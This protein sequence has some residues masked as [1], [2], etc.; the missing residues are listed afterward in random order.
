MLLLN[1]PLITHTHLI[2]C[3]RRLQVGWNQ[4]GGRN[5]S[6]RI[7]SFKKGSFASKRIYRFI[8]F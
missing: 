6:G 4:T 5:S 7:T 2:R 3:A 1:K 8:D